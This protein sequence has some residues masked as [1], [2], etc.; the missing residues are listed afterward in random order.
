MPTPFQTE[1][2]TEYA[3]G[4]IIL[5]GRLSART[6]QL[7]WKWQGDDYFTVIAALLFTAELVMLELIGQYGSI[8]GMSDELALKLTPQEQ[9]N[10]VVGSKCLLAGW[11]LYTTLIWCRKSRELSGSCST[12]ANHITVKACML[13]FYNRLTYVINE[14]HCHF[15]LLTSISL[16]LQQHHLVKI[17]GVICIV[18][19]IAT[20]TVYLT[21]C[22]PIRRLWQVYPYPGDECA[23]NISKYLALVVTNVL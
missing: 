2:W 22:H 11:I 21:H 15:V 9:K 20:I 10:L 23:L 4:M 5:I 16:K 3:V 13:F 18:A 7:G 12:L 17:T 14:F 19:Y 8:T 6:W 1:A